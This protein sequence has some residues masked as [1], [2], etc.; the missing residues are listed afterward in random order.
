MQEA[1]T[2]TSNHSAQAD[3]PPTAPATVPKPA[4]GLS[5]LVFDVA[6]MA[7]VAALVS[8]CMLVWGPS[9]IPGL[10]K[11]EEPPFVVVNID[12]L[13][14][15]QMMAMSQKVRE[16]TVEVAEMPAKSAAFAQALVERVQS[17]ADAGKVVLRADSVVAAPDG[18]RDLTDSIRDDLIKSGAMFKAPK[19]EE[20]N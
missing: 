12:Q 7:I 19:G 3:V 9:I 5:G 17:H 15:E 1:T 14:R 4:T 18:V 6:V 10:T 20:P 16:G 11:T 13:G 2:S 8:F